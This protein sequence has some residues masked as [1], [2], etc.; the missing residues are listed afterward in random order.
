MDFLLVNI[1]KTM[2]CLSI[3]QQPTIL[4][5]TAASPAS[6]FVFFRTDMASLIM[7]L[8]CTHTISARKQRKL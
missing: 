3:S 5:C 1:N 2:P 4:H 6:N 7:K 8:A